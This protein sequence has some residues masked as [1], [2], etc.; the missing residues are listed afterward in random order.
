M[1]EPIRNGLGW[2]LAGIFFSVLQAIGL[3]LLAN[4]WSKLDRLDVNVQATLTKI[5]VLETRVA[6]FE[7]GRNERTK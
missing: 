7:S 2:K 5:A 3:F 4:L 6:T 1:S